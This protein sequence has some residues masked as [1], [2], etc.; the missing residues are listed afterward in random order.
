MLIDNVTIR[1]KAGD[2]GRGAVGFNK[3]KGSL[4]PVGGN[5]GNG[6]SIFF[7]GVSDLASLS[8]FKQCIETLS[9]LLKVIDFFVCPS[10]K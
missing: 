6:G 7:E 9:S 4:G 5:G 2:G 8:Q 1:V 3:T 10:R